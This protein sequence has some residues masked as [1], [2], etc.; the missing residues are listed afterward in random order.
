MFENR[1]AVLR[2]ISLLGLAVLAFFSLRSFPKPDPLDLEI[3]AFLNR[4]NL[5]GAVVVLSE[6]NAAPQSR[7]YGLADASK[8]R[9]MDPADRF[10]LASLSKPVTA[11]A[12]LRQLDR[13][14]GLDLDSFAAPHISVLRRSVDPRVAQITFL[15]LLRHSAGGTALSGLRISF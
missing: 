5:P 1:Q 15:D 7:A 14:P 10:R 8:G 3:E 4:H 2:L 6:P 13:T 11:T 9:A 12:V